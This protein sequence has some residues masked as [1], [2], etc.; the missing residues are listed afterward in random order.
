MQ[1]KINNILE[2]SKNKADEILLYSDSLNDMISFNKDTGSKVIMCFDN[3]KNV[4]V[5]FLSLKEIN[6]KILNVKIVV[7]KM[8]LNICL[9]G[10]PV[11]ITFKNNSVEYKTI[12]LKKYK[13]FKI[14]KKENNY[15]LKYIFGED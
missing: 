2:E 10:N 8:H 11:S 13:E 1:K 15:I 6:K 12:S 7:N 5:G 9:S 14:K 3:N 4:E